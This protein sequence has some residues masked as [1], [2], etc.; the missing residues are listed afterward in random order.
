MENFYGFAAAIPAQARYA[1]AF[2]I[3]NRVKNFE[4][5]TIH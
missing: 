3:N 5:G 2:T 1:P 4:V